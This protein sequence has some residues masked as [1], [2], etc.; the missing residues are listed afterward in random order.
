[1]KKIAQFISNI[2]H[3]ANV[4]WANVP[5]GTYVRYVMA[6]IA[7]INNL[8]LACGKHPIEADENAVFVFVSLIVNVLVI[9]MN[10]YKDNPTSKEAIVTNALMKTL[11]KSDQATA[12]DMID[13]IRGLVSG[14]SQDTI[15]APSEEEES[16]ESVEEDTDMNN[17]EENDGSSD[18][19]DEPTEEPSQSEPIDGNPSDT[20]T[21]DTGTDM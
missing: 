6:I 9:L 18:I 10:T 17:N 20:E 5:V 2:A 14:S 12:N 21:Q 8:L 1:M 11:K 15:R 4:D 13:I 19:I 3:A 7:S 16:F